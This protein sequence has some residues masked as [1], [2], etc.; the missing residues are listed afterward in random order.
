MPKR[1]LFNLKNLGSWAGIKKKRKKNNDGDLEAEAADKE[2][3]CFH[4][5]SAINSYSSIENRY[6]QTISFL[7]QCQYSRV[8]PALHSK[9]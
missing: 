2:N 7:K 4:L 5:Y 3:V 9:L 8:P 6:P 1:K